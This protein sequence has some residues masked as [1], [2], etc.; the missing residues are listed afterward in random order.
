[1]HRVF[2]ILLVLFF[3][4]SRTTSQLPPQCFKPSG[5]S[6]DWYRDCLDKKYPCE[7][8]GYPYALAYADKFCK[9]YDTRKSLFSPE[10]WKWVSGV[11]KCLQEA[12][13]PVL[14][15]TTKATCKEIRKKGFES[16]APCYLKPDKNIP[17]ICDLGCDVYFKVFKVI[18]GSFTSF[19]TAWEVIK[20][21]WFIAKKC[22]FTC[23][24]MT[25]R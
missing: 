9:L 21:M 10:E 18:K 12:L 20:A 3:G 2:Y 11:R 5:S 7:A 14:R 1:M 23:S 25:L 4:P 24:L 19:N 6:C 22:G 13:V 15:Q 17:S 16:H 8:S